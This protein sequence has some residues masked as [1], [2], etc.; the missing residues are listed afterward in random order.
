MKNKKTLALAALTAAGVGTAGYVS[1]IPNKEDRKPGEYP[2]LDYASYLFNHKKDVYK[3][4]RDLGLPRLQLLKHD[5]SKLY[6]SSF[7][8]YRDYWFGPKGVHAVGGRDKVDEE[9]SERFNREAE[10]H[11]NREEHHKHKWD[12]NPVPV[13]DVDPSTRKEMFADWYSVSKAS[14]EDPSK[15]PDIKT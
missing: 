3:G 6:P 8:T 7:K 12:K 11:Y 13:K 4:G 10:K 5:Y 2:N 9:L 15:F 1:S 14:S